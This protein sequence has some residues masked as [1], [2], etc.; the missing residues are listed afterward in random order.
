MINLCVSYGNEETQEWETILDVP[1]IPYAELYPNEEKVRDSYGIN[2]HPL[3]LPNG[4]ELKISVSFDPTSLG[5]SYAVQSE[6][7]NLLSVFGHKQNIND[8]EPSAGILTPGGVD[9]SIMIGKTT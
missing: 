3:V 9:I 2:D 5:I 4:E 6:G 8:F 7:K 1:L